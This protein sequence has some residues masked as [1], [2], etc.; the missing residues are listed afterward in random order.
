MGDSHNTKLSPHHYKTAY[1]TKKGGK[2]RHYFRN[3]R[4]I[5]AAIS[6]A[7]VPFGLMATQKIMPKRNITTKRHKRK[8][9]AKR[10]EHK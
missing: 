6:S 2:S 10:H 5:A 9:S 3:Q 4:V 1:K 7:L 8:G